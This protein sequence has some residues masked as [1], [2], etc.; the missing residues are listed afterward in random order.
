[1]LEPNVQ[2]LA[3]LRVFSVLAD[4]ASVSNPFE[5]TIKHLFNR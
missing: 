2:V 4:S 1:M 5:Q 3:V